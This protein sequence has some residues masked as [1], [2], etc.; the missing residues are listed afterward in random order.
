MIQVPQLNRSQAATAENEPDHAQYRGFPS[1]T[2]LNR[3]K[4]LKGFSNKNQFTILTWNSSETFLGGTQT[5]CVLYVT[6]I[7]LLMK[8]RLHSSFSNSSGRL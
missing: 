6:L 7:C 5:Q 4:S 2:S 1:E 8:D 3:V